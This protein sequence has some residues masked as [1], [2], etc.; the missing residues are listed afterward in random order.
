MTDSL[1]MQQFD[2]QHRNNISE[3]TV[4]AEEERKK[5]AAEKREMEKKKRDQ[6]QYF[7][8]V[9]L[10]IVGVFFLVI[11]S[12]LAVPEWLIEMIAFFSILSVFEFVVLVLDNNIKDITHGEPIKNFGIKMIIFSIL[13]PLH[14][15]IETRVT[16]YLKK[17]KLIIN[18]KSFSIKKTLAKIWPWLSEKPKSA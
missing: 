7:L 9:L 4:R 14:H 12:S 5:V 1:L 15:L 6:R 16:N 17:N 3:L 8:I 2:T 13:F 18:P 10:I 11:L